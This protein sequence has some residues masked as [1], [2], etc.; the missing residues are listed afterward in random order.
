MKNAHFAAHALKKSIV[1]GSFCHT[2]V[3]IWKILYN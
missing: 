3:I 2:V 1:M